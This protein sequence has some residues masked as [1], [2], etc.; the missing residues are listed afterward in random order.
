MGEQRR[1][2]SIRPYRNVALLVSAFIQWQEFP[3]LRSSNL[4]SFP[5]L[6]DKQ[7]QDAALLNDLQWLLNVFPENS[8]ASSGRHYKTLFDCFFPVICH[9][10]IIIP[11]LQQKQLA[12]FFPN[13]NRNASLLAPPIKIL[14]VLQVQPESFLLYQMVP[15]HRI[16]LPSIFW[17]EN[18]LLY[19]PLRLSDYILSRSHSCTPSHALFY[20]LMQLTYRLKSSELSN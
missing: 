6:S 14:S 13:K 3:S 12:G 11:N 20:P 7:R 5:S 10:S 1:R 17:G 16:F 15:S 8:K 18:S 9:T 19:F 2:A 4:Q